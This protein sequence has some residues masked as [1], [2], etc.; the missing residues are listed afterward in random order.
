MKD[1]NKEEKKRK[2]GGGG[3][4]SGSEKKTG[5]CQKA[6]RHIGSTKIL[7]KPA[8]GSS[9]LFIGYKGWSRVQAGTEGAAAGMEKAPACSKSPGCCQLFRVVTAPKPC[10]QA[11]GLFIEPLDF[12]SPCVLLVVF[13]LRKQHSYWDACLG[14][15]S[16]SQGRQISVTR[17]PCFLNLV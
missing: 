7:V 3:D 13:S 2:K 9:V 14:G 11:T 10:A 17:T 5:S 1:K 12:P 16:G 15:G 6:C 4:L 8:L